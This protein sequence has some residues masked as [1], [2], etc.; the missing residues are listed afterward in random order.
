MYRK[1]LEENQLKL[2]LKLTFQHDNNLKPIAKATVEWL[3]NNKVKSSSG[4]VRAPT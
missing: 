3:R 1:V 4:P 2:G